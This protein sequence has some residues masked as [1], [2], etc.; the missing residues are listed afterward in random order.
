MGARSRFFVALRWGLA[1]GVALLSLAS[2]AP[3]ARAE[4]PSA[5]SCIRFWG[6]A[7][8]NGVGYNH[9]VH[10][11]NSCAVSAECVVSTDVNPEPQRVEVWPRRARRW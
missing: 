4:R 10:L 1:L 3:R 2:L 9:L 11:A 7:R 8:F 6:E 5:D